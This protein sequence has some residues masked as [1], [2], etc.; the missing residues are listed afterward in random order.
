MQRKGKLTR[1][2]CAIHSSGRNI[3]CENQ[4]QHKIFVINN[5]I[6]KLILLKAIDGWERILPAQSRN[7]KHLAGNSAF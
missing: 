1:R 2:H 6:Q 3:M 7:R 4:E 5:I